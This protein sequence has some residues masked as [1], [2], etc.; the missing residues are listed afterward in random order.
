MSPARIR[1]RICG[2]LTW[3][4]LLVSLPTR[5]AEGG[6]PAPASLGEAGSVITWTNSL[7]MRFRTV[8]GTRV[9]FSIWETRVQDYQAFVEDRKHPWSPPG[10]AHGPQ[11]PVA[12]VNWE[13]S[14]A[15]CRWLTDREREAGN[16][17]AKQ[18]YRL[19]TDQEWSIAAGVRPETGKTP[20][21]RMKQHRV[22][23]WGSY[24]PPVAGDGNYGEKL[25]ID[26]FPA[27]A[28]VGSSRPNPA[29]LFDLGGN[30]W[31]WTEDW[32]NEAGVTKAL[33]GGSFSDSQ[34]S[35][36]LTTYRLNGT[37]N[38]TNEDFGFRLVL[39]SP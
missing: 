36:L 2:G 38:L 24:W 28:P 39:E 9:L 35:Y 25:K 32:Y 3:A 11:H 20:E 18:K 13:D 5:G 23:P 1:S 4:C 37:M 14:T 17:S 29:G 33:R 10:F 15:F 16:L 27:T 19:P 8:P 26:P 31:E 12:N 30:V 6:G 22:W 34:P 7:G 21:A